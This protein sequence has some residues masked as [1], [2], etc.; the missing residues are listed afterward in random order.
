M[1]NISRYLYIIQRMSCSCA[2]QDAFK[3]LQLS[4]ADQERRKKV[5]VIKR[6]ILNNFK[7]N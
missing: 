3:K 5:C 2:C 4:V 7:T 1:I 6:N